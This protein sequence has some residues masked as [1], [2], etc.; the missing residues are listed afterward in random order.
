LTLTRIGLLSR[1]N[2]LSFALAPASA[3]AASYDTAAG[4][5]G[6]RDDGLAVTEQNLNE[7]LNSLKPVVMQLLT[8]P[9]QPLSEELRHNTAETVT[10]QAAVLGGIK[11]AQTQAISMELAST[12]ANMQ[13]LNLYVA[14]VLPPGEPISLDP[15]RYCMRMVTGDPIYLSFKMHFHQ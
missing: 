1:G 9:E 14:K 5:D 6:A 15:E 13:Y 10:R 7:V 4:A 2:S 11:Q 12:S 8:N 3:Y